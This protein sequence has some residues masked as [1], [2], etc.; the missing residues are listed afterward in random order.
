MCTQRLA[1]TYFIFYVFLRWGLALS[2]RLE[3]SGVIIAHCSFTLSGPSD[4]PTLPSQVAVIIHM[5]YC[6]RLMFK[7]FIETVFRY[8]TPAGLRTPG[9]KQSSQLGLP[10]CGDYRCP[11][12]HPTNFFV[13]LVETGFYR[14]SQ[15]GSRDLPTSASQ[16]AGITGMSHCARPSYV[17]L[18]LHVDLPT[19][20]MKLLESSY[21]GT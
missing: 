13:F 18:L 4:P 20:P 3:F 17:F 19:S 11:P 9:L 15:N 1:S 14:V 6:A 5:C 21:L 12:P 7:F 16:S 2:P 10:T 8:V